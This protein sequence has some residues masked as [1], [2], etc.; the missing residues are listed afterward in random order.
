MALGAAHRRPIDRAGKP[1][2]HIERNRVA[3][4]RRAA[5]EPRP[6]QGTATPVLHR[7]ARKVSAASAQ[8]RATPMATG[9][10]GGSSNWT[11]EVGRRPGTGWDRPTIRTL[12]DRCRQEARH[13]RSQRLPV[14]ERD[15]W[16][17][18]FL[19]PQRLE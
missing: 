14:N 12:S 19:T 11:G 16:Q 5:P 2:A 13:Q 6:G 18:C 1:D 17:R 8:R 7:A 4:Y 9:E 15:T 3:A 10:V